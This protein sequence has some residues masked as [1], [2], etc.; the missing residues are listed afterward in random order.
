MT[1]LEGDAFI[2]SGIETSHDL[3]CWSGWISA[4]G[5]SYIQGVFP[6]ICTFPLV[7]LN[8][9]SCYNFFI[10]LFVVSQ[11][12][13][14][15]VS[16]YLSWLSLLFSQFM[17]HKSDVANSGN[18][19]SLPSWISDHLGEG[20]SYMTDEVNRSPASPMEGSPTLETNLYPPFIPQQ[21]RKITL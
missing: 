19:N 14:A 1:L 15:S 3:R 20:S 4:F 7:L 13:P 18:L 21:R 9:C 10:T 11:F 17:S 8:C 6:F 12:L 2:S 5:I 16:A